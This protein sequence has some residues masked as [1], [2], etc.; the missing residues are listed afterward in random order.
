MITFVRGRVVHVGLERLIVDV[1]G[2]GMSMICPAGALLD[3]REGELVT[4]HTALV[5]REDSWTMYAFAS[6][7]QQADFE[8]LQ[9]V[10]GIGPRLALAL[11][12]TLSPV[13]LRRAISASDLVALTKVPGVGRKGAQRMV[14]E[15]TGKLGAVS[16]DS[17]TS[18]TA[19]TG[20]GWRDSVVAGLVSLGW[21][22]RE[23]ETA[24]DAVDDEAT[25]MSAAGPID[26]SVLLR[27]ALRSLDRA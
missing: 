9:T 12:A 11:V 24:A 19:S 10:S 1:G 7:E 2:F 6:E 17:G 27:S 25:A 13:E 22:A 14:I 8:V 23:A 20:S 21:S 18:P 5:V 4:V 3:L 16:L 15:L 26:V